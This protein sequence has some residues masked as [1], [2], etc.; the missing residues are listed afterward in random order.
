MTAAGVKLAGLAVETAASTAVRG[1]C[2]AGTDPACVDDWRDNDGHVWADVDTA[3][4]QVRIALETWLDA[5]KAGT[6]PAALLAI[7][8]GA[9][10]HLRDLLTPLGVSLP[11]L[12][13]L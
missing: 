10:S 12:A 8:V 2:P 11:D 9:Y 6:D 4:A 13:A 5:L 1:A 7:L 3:F